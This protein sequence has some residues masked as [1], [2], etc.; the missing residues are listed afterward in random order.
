MTFAMK[1]YVNFIEISFPISIIFEKAHGVGFAPTRDFSGLVT[2]FRRR[3]VP[4][5]HRRGCG[6]E[7]GDASLAVLFF[8]RPFRAASASTSDTHRES[9]MICV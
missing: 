3:E 9:H 5:R 6:A 4:L 1:L 7:G 8:R 2:G